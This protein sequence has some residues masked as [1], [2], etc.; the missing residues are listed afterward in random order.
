MAL[1]RLA[2]LVIP[3]V[4]GCGGAQLASSPE[5]GVALRHPDGVVLDAPPATPAPS[6]ASSAD[7][8]VAL[9]EPHDD[10]A[11]R[12]I[13]L[14]YVR[15]FV[16]QDLDAL[17]GL[18][19]SSAVEL[20][21]RTRTGRPGIIEAWQRRLRTLDYSRVAV[22][23]VLRLDRIDRLDFD[24]L[25]SPTGGGPNARPGDMVPGDMLVRVPIARR[26][27]EPRLFGSMLILLLRREQGQLAIAGVH[28]DDSP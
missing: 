11:I 1:R 6:I 19:T 24:Q 23:D 4:T 25:S 17:T 12:E 14:A 18:L 7:G 16:R 21:A 3:L 2:A 15:G 22:N 8:V 5:T 28:E 20:G 27:G 9:R 10:E 26:A 13:L